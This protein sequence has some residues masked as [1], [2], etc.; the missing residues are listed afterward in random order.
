MGFS[1][2]PVTYRSRAASAER[3]YQTL[4]DWTR[5]IMQL[6]AVATIL[7]Y[8]YLFY[9]LFMGDVG[10]WATLDAANRARIAHNIQNAVMAV[11]IA[12]GALLLTACILFYDE[13]SLGYT[14]VAA[15]VFCY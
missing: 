12:L 3:T 10:Q 15:S 8:A 1:A 9:G 14:L 11:N 6:A 13:E 2:V 4:M 7:L 5:R